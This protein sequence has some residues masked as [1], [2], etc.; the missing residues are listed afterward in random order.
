MKYENDYRDLRLYYSDFL[1]IAS[2]IYFWFL[3]LFLPLS[4]IL[5]A[6]PILFL[7]HMQKLNKKVSHIYTFTHAYAPSQ[8][9]NVI[10]LLITAE[11][12]PF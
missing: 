7:W 2:L 11:R 6:P 8:G 1:I 12:H 9:L 4:L 10:I 5:F 3:Y